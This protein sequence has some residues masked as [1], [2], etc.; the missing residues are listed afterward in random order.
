MYM[1][2]HMCWVLSTHFP[3]MSHYVCIHAFRCVYIHEYICMYVYLHKHTYMYICMH[4]CISIYVHIHMCLDIH[5]Q[6]SA[7]LLLDFTHL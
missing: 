2:V 7:L 6:N 4:M 5:S 1:D 3:I